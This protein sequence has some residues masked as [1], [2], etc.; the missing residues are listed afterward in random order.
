MN[1]FATLLPF[2]ACAAW[3]AAP[4][5]TARSHASGPKQ[6]A[7]EVKQVLAHPGNAVTSA[8]KATGDA[9]KTAAVQTKDMV[10]T[11]TA[12]VTGALS[13]P[14]GIPEHYSKIVYPE[15]TYQPPYP[16]DHRVAL[17]RGVVGY[18]VPDS[19]LALIQMQILFGHPALPKQPAD[20]APLGLYSAMLKSGGTARLKPEQL[21]DSLEF[22]AASVGAGIGR[23]QA[24][25]SL[26]ALKKDAYALFDLLP[27]VALRPGLDQEVF[28]VQK[29][30][31]LENLKHRYDTPNGVIGVAYEHV[32]FGP[33]AINWL[34]N[35]K[36]VEAVTTAKLKTWIGSGYATKGMVIGVSGQFDR[37]EMIAQLNKLIAKF[38]PDYKG[39][40]DSLPPFPGPQAPGVYV[41]D[42][43]FT[44]AT[45]R[46]G[47]PGVKRP[48]P[49][50]YRLIVASYI[51]GDGG[52]TSRLMEKVRSNE[53]LAYGIDSD[54]GSDYYRK[55]T[56]N[57]S[58]Q[59]KVE[60]AAY[61]VKLVLSE[62]KRMAKDG[63]TDEELQRAKDGLIKSLPATFDTPEAT[64]HIFAQGEIWHRSP[65]HFTEYIKT[66][67]N[68]TKAEVETA[69]RKYFDPD[70]M[71]IVVVGNK[72]ELMKTD[73]RNQAALSH[74]GPVHEMTIADIEARK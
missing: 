56:V 52:F 27:E 28:K 42:K 65:D 50:Y 24:E 4:A 37:Q 29:R 9:V 8:A 68:M 54:V 38:P 44:Q 41:I 7:V 55:S 12:K 69:F 19:T 73:E 62:M 67:S 35:A 26:D 57:V 2:I 32:M 6:A 20:V 47:A 36:E 17:D 33:N 5:D 51:F 13:S 61:A 25:L 74:Y 21:E 3:A 15:F 63:I 59:T 66:I 53:G 40:T 22:V 45:I 48:D 70:S 46:L 43:P 58:L 64:A 16:K 31:Y 14:A 1:R 11:A 72:A 49:D 39:G 18:L 30:A 23:Y 34:A 71:R 10:K 60:T